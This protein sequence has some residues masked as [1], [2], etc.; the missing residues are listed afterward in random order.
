MQLPPVDGVNVIYG[1]CSTACKVSVYGK[2]KAPA[3][4]QTCS[5]GYTKTWQN[6]NSVSVPVV[7]NNEG[8]KAPSCKWEVTEGFEIAGFSYDD[9]AGLD[10]TAFL[11]P[12]VFQIFSPL[13]ANL[14]YAP[15]ENAD[16]R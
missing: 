3:L 10:A 2:E 14:A 4:T 6:V 15:A 7:E 1:T 12:N 9:G 16:R 8:Y 11:S 13:P 5:N